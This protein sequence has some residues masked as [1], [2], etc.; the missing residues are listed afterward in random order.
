M[1]LPVLVAIAVGLSWLIALSATQVRVV[2]AAREVARAAA[3]DEPA[4]EAI[5][6]GRR[7][8]PEGATIH[9]TT[10]GSSVI[11]TVEAEV[12]GPAGVFSFLLPVQL[13]SEAVA[14]RE[15]P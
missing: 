7:V 12:G 15:A 6:R 3:R 14:A 4:A 2:D 13:S 11:A 8:A 5:A 10:E 9:L 1:V